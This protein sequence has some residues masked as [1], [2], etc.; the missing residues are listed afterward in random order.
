M[1]R[2]LTELEQLRVQVAELQEELGE[3][4]RQYGALEVEHGMGDEEVARFDA[5]IRFTHCEWRCLKAVLRASS[6]GISR[7]ALIEA[8]IPVGSDA[9]GWR[10]ADVFI[11]RCRQKLRQAGRPELIVTLWGFGYRISAGDAASLNA[12]LRHA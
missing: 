6:R 1:N 9:E 4:R 12:W 5:P 8:T 7:L 10:H 2:P 11:C 3:W